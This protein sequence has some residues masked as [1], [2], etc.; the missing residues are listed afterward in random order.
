MPQAFLDSFGAKI[1]AITDCFEDNI[2]Q[3]PS[4]EPR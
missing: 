3:P 4:M 1:A 2:E